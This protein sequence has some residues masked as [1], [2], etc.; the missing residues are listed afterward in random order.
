MI[1]PACHAPFVSMEFDPSG[2]V[3]TCCA[4]QLYPMGNVADGTLADIW[5]GPR[6]HA[7]RAALADGDLTLGC[8]SCHWAMAHGNDAS[9]ARLYDA[10][11]VA[12]AN[13][14][15]PSRMTFALSNRCNLECVMC[16]GELS[17]KIR[18]REGRPPLP[19]VYHD[20]FFAQLDQFL[21]HLSHASFL[22]GEPFLIAEN[23]RV[24]EQM[25]GL[26]ITTRCA[27]VTNATR[28]DA[29]VE[30]VLAALAFD[31]TVSLDGVT[32]ATVEG[33]RRNIGFAEALD[34]A[35]R[36]RAYTDRSG[37]AFGFNFCLMRHNWTELGAF[38]AFADGWDA[39]VR[40]ISV[41]E[42]GHS[43]H[44]L[45]EAP[46]A[47]VLAGLEAEDERRMA[48]LTRNR[49]TWA[50]EVNQV[51]RVLA[52]RR[53]GV[54]AA[55]RQPVPLRGPL[56]ERPRSDAVADGGPGAAE[57]RAHQRITRWAHG[58]P[59]ARLLV[60]ADRLV[61]SVDHGQ[62]DR[63]GV[64]GGDAI[65]AD[66]DDVLRRTEVA[67]GRE[68]YAV[69]RWAEDGVVDQTFL[70][71]TGVPARGGAGSVLR[72]ISAAVPGGAVSFVAA[73]RFYDRGRPVEVRPR[74]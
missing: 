7:L 37:T 27:V 70:A 64:V 10:F 63:T 19:P 20:D 55:I 43:L 35:E 14:D 9:I 5:R 2:N 74:G 21:P 16:N 8:N 29:K 22:G 54:E 31:V 58:G 68:F 34:N 41:S 11:P 65:G 47:H 25:S 23:Y 52:E 59:V 32:A 66:I 49:T 46:L 4:N 1:D 13:P 12:S 50:A 73:D 51:R 24:W 71:T 57:A 53:A 6:A 48:T 69:E 61:R 3:F 33:I 44:D 18:A 45:D 15:R 36:F 26:A 67:I 40:V 38:L 17:S 28:F 39:D 60:G 62:E 30:A 56:I 72:V 42:P